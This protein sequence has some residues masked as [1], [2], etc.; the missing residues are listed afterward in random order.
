MNLKDSPTLYTSTFKASI[1]EI[2]SY[3]KEQVYPQNAADFLKELQKAI[4][5]ITKYPEANPIV[6]QIPTKYNWYRFK[7]IKRRYKIIFKVLK[8][9]LIFLAVVHTS[10]DSKEVARLRTRDYS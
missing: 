8:S 7:I 5:I 1:D 6:R 3:C 10:R 2:V 4:R 9:K